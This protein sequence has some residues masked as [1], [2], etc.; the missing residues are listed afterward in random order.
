MAQLRQNAH[1]IATAKFALARRSQLVRHVKW[2]TVQVSCFTSHIHSLKT[3]RSHPGIFS[4]RTLTPSLSTDE[5]CQNFDK[6]E[7]QCPERNGNCVFAVHDSSKPSCTDWCKSHGSTCVG[8]EN[9]D[10]KHGCLGEDDPGSCNDKFNS[11]ICICK[12][13]PTGMFGIHS[14]CTQKRLRRQRF[15]YL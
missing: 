6:F 8:E 4:T 7:R 13:K 14:P 1:E 2:I 12:S 9:T 11:H 10:T 5:A 15:L 3:R